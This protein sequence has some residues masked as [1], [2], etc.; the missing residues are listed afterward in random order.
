MR[1]K[2]VPKTSLLGLVNTAALSCFHVYC[3]CVMWWRTF[4]N[5]LLHKKSWSCSSHTHRERFVTCSPEN[6]STYSWNQY[7]KTFYVNLWTNPGEL[8]R[9]TSF[10]DGR[11]VVWLLILIFVTVYNHAF[12]CN[13]KESSTHKVPRVYHNFSP[14]VKRKQCSLTFISAEIDKFLVF[15]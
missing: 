1:S 14:T 3:D 5:V 4:Q 6:S 11:E 7:F 12:S 13:K 2:W 15:C 9:S 10:T 8:R